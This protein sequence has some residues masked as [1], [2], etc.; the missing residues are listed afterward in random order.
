MYGFPVKNGVPPLGLTTVAVP[1]SNPKHVT[2]VFVM[3]SVDNT[4]GSVIVTEFVVKVQPLASVITHEYVPADRPFTKLDVLTKL[5]PF[6]PIQLK[7]YS[8]TPPDNS[9]SI[10]PSFCP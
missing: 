3:G 5:Y 4:R 10:E 7:L 9:M 6:G 8:P 1:S 2:S